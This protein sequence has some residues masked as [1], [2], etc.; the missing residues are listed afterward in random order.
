MVIDGDAGE[1]GHGLALGAG[2]QDGD[3]FG[4]EVHGVLGTE[5]DAVGDA[6]EAVGVGDFGDRDH[7]AADDG[8]AA[9]VFLGE[10]EDQLD[11]VDGR[12]EAGDDDA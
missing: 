9:A 10:I 11:A 7:A 4:R 3:L 8:Y 2:N 5:E 1:G 12:A 6:E